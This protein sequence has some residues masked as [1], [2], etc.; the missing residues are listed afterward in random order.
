MLICNN[1]G[2]DIP[3]SMEH[4]PTCHTFIGFP[5]VRDVE[6]EEE[7]KALELRYQQAI[8]AAEANGSHQCL[9]SFEDSLRKTCAV[10]NVDIDYLYQFITSN[11]A[12]YSN[13]SLQVKGEVRKPAMD[14][15]D[16][17]RRVVEAI[18]FGGYAEKIRYAVLS[19]DGAGLQSYGPYTMKLREI[20]INKRATLLEDNSYHFVR[21]HNIQWGKMIPAGYMST[22]QERHKLA[23]SKLAGQIFPKT[24]EEA[25]AEILLFSEGNRET[26]NYIEVHIYLKGCSKF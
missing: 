26:D 12:L 1:C 21:K 13:Y 10:I 6:K 4:C 8:K 23:V 9:K 24:S 15:D 22:W 20:A 18:L 2:S 3:D 17:D 16:R 19:L 5:N 7:I 11:K 25:Y 14:Q